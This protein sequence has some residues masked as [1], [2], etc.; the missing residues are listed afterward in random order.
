MKGRRLPTLYRMRNLMKN[1]FVEYE[2]YKDPD[3][4][5]TAVERQVVKKY[6]LVDLDDAE[7]HQFAASI[8]YTSYP[9]YYQNYILAGMIATQLQEALSD[10]FGEEKVSDPAVAK[11]IIE[12]LYSPGEQQ[13]WTERIRNAT[14]KNIET[15]A[16][17][18]KLGIETSRL[19][20]K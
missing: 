7:P 17:L 8:W 9:C 4:D 20:T 2:M 14:G 12:H 18:R 19:I 1:F 5:M 13:E 15:G 3:R 10:E 6:L 16:Y 11:W